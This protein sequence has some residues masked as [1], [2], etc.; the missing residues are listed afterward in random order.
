[1]ADI[2]YKC[3]ACA[4]PIEFDAGSG[5]MKCGYCLSV[6]EV[7][8]VERFNLDQARAEQAR[9]ARTPATVGVS[10]GSPQTPTPPSSPMDAPDDPAASQDPASDPPAQGHWAGGQA[11]Y[12]EPGDLA[13]MQPMI[14]NSCGAEIIADPQTISTRCGFCN[15]TFIAADRL[16]RT[17]V[18]DFVIPF[19]LDKKAMLAAFKKATEGKFLLPRTFR[20]EHYLSQATGAYLPYWF[21]D[22]TVHGTITFRAEK[23]RQWEDSRAIHTEVRE[24]LVQRSGSVD[25]RALPVCGTS[26]LEAARSEGVEPF[27]AEECQPFATP[28]LSGYAASAY[29]IE[30]EATVQRADTRA[31]ESLQR[32][33]EDCVRGYD[34]ARVVDSN[35]QVDRS[36]IWYVLLPVWLIVI[37]Y[38]GKDHPFAINGQ[39]GE[40]VGT[41]PISKGKLRALNWG[42]FLGITI[43][44]TTLAWLL[45]GAL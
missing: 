10:T 45:I 29:D 3:P 7:A 2:Q 39:T 41:F 34:S 30:A 36:A 24:Y 23:R 13:G 31:H 35:V 18:P 40:V 17:R 6:F 21:H 4:A 22:G 12:L 14:C 19:A 5:K 33:L 26:K 8:E 37:G 1:M 16:A 9:S 28:Y 42:F 11:G 38:D 44:V 15:N 32:L 43:L 27:R 25:F 20:D